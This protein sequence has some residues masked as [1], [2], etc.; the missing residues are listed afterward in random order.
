MRRP[1]TTAGKENPKFFQ[2][3]GVDLYSDQW[4]TT[5]GVY[6]Y[7]SVEC[8]PVVEVFAGLCALLL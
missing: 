1:E 5:V 2:V 7:Y 8:F 4:F 6:G 3:L